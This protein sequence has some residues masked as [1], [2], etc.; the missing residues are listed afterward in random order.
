MNRKILLMKSACFAL[1]PAT[2]FTN[3]SPTT[4]HKNVGTNTPELYET[5]YVDLKDVFSGE[6]QGTARMGIFQF[7]NGSSAT[8]YTYFA[9]LL[10]ILPRAPEYG[11]AIPVTTQNPEQA[12][13]SIIDDFYF[14]VD[15]GVVS[16]QL[17]PI[18]MKNVSLNSSINVKIDGNEQAVDITSILPGAF[19][20]LPIGGKYTNDSDESDQT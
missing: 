8:D 14:N 6:V 18:I 1:L 19:S 17:V 3:L 9:S 13:Q 5:E 4:S 15:A 7:K 2:L 11:E 12:E 10:N 20:L 16:E